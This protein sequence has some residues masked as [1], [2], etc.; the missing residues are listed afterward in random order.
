[1]AQDQQRIALNGGWTQITNDDV[2]NISFQALG[3]N[4]EVHYSASATAPSDSEYGF[5]YASGDGEQNSE[6][7][8]LTALS[9]AV[10]VFARSAV[11][12]VSIQVDHA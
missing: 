2:T 3:G 6:L 4:V 12:G 10:R 8:N 5:V 7:S 11:R 1:M 9:G